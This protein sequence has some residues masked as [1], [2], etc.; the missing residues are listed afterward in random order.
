VICI[1]KYLVSLA[2]G[3]IKVL[4][5]TSGLLPESAA[6][7]GERAMMGGWFAA[8][9]QALASVEHVQLGVAS[10]VGGGRSTNIELGGVQ[11]FVVPAPAIGY[12][13]LRP[14]PA[15][16]DRYQEIIYQFSPDVIHVHGTEWYG[17][18]VTA[19][20]RITC[21][22]VVTIQGLISYSRQHLNGHLGAIETLRS[23]S[24]REWLHFGGIWKDQILW[25][26]RA[27]IELE[28]IRRN[29]RFIGPTLWDRAHLREINPDAQYF[30][31][32]E[33]VR[34]EFLEQKWTLEGAAKHTI[35]APSAAYPLKGFHVLL[36]AVAI[37]RHEFPDIKV[38]VPLANLSMPRSLP[39]IRANLRRTGYE[40]YLCGLIQK[41]NLAE[42]VVSLGQLTAVEM[43]REMQQAHVFAMPSFVENGSMARTEAFAVGVPTVVSLTGGTPHMVCDGCNTL[44]FAAGDEAVLAE[45]IRRI[46]TDDSLAE[47]LSQAGRESARRRHTDYVVEQMSE[48]YAAIANNQHP[49]CLQHAN[50]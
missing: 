47:R 10:R 22:S 41:F 30:Q 26:R 24:L 48:I 14:T 1:C 18:L 27:E 11:H 8:L 32:Y 15:M 44:G 20:E 25:N 40:N 36:K 16:M 17:G 35:F 5:L 2:M 43:A 29:H 46:F 7:L 45:Q 12:R 31:C 19:D 38:R 49:I 6:A 34:K 4:W 37:L 13:L 39:G 33:M 21:P 9:S 28:I 42:H 50:R 23:R 3:H